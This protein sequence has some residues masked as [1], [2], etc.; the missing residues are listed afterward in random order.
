MRVIQS[1]LGIEKRFDKKG[2]VYW[3]TH[4]ILDDGEQV[5]GYGMGFSTGDKVEAF[6]DPVYDV[7]K[8]QRHKPTKKST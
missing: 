4:A 5:V 7:A 8:M 1:I 2:K 3:R 6:F